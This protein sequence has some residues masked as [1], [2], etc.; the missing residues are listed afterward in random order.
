MGLSRLLYQKQYKSVTLA[1]NSNY[2]NALPITSIPEM[3]CLSLL[4]FLLKSQKAAIKI[5]KN[6]LYLST[7]RYLRLILLLNMSF[8]KSS[9]WLFCKSL[10]AMT[11]V[12]V[13]N[14]FLAAMSI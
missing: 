8:G 7:Y 3:I 6:T 9:N 11:T 14:N 13:C 12:S 1:T 10:S 5:R 4:L 2:F